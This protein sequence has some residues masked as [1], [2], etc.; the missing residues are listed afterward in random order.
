MV[1]L[2][3]ADATA[4][5][6]AILDSGLRLDEAVGYDGERL[7]WILD[8]RVALLQQPALAK[9]CA[10]LWSRLKPYRPDVIA[11]MTLSADPLI[12]GLLYEAL[13]DGYPLRGAI[14]RKEPKKYGLRR[15]VEGPSLQQG[16]RVILVDDLINGG[17]TIERATEA[18][19]ERLIRLVAVGVVVDFGVSAARRRLR[20]RN[21]DLHALF[22]LSDLGLA[23]QLP[24]GWDL[25]P[26]SYVSPQ[27]PPDCTGSPSGKVQKSLCSAGHVALVTQSASGTVCTLPTLPGTWW[28]D[29]SIR[30][31]DVRPSVGGDQVLVLHSVNEAGEGEIFALSMCEGR[32]LWSRTVSSSLSAMTALPGRQTFVVSTP[33]ETLGLSLDDGRVL[34][35]SGRPARGLV[36]SGELCHGQDDGGQLWACKLEDGDP[37]WERRVGTRTDPLLA[38][39]ETTVTVMVHRNSVLALDAES[40]STKWLSTLSEPSPTAMAHA[41][42][43]LWAVN[44]ER[45]LWLL[46]DE[47]GRPGARWNDGKYHDAASAVAPDSNGNLW[48]LH[49][50][51]AL[52]CFSVNQWGE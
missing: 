9:I 50:N 17:K 47:R 13:W 36:I 33:H 40:G 44:T 3:S 29:G 24:W 35:S 34:W 21:V 30:N 4:V 28:S 39:S 31:G 26:V 22:T 52:A 43:D 18:L 16:A 27:A 45:S 49:Q 41:G 2:N 48:A 7:P 19:D 20:E 6:S 42:D 14:I 51:G 15:L 32:H 38:A 46:S 1:W 25:R 11:G 23:P 8:C 37:V 10:E 12:V 5:G